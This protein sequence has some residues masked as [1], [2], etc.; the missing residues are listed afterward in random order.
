MAGDFG[1]TRKNVSRLNLDSFI[2]SND[3][4]VLAVVYI[5]SPEL[6]LGKLFG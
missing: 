1:P 4:I 2:R 6:V 3:R 5:F